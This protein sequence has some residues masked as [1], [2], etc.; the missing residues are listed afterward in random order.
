SLGTVVAYNLLRREG[1]AQGWKVPLLVTLGSPLAVEAIRRMLRPLQSIGC[2]V[3]WYNAMDERDVVAL[4]PLDAANFGIEPA[5]ENNT[6]VRTETT[7]RQ[8]ISGYLED[9]DV[10]QRIHA[11]LAAPA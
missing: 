4:Y 10:A 3:H 2:V 11:A 1:A 5:I 7:H 6:A 8:G 9:K